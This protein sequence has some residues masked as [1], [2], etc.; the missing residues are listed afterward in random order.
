MIK[1]YLRVRGC[2]EDRVLSR[3]PVGRIWVWETESRGTKWGGRERTIQK[4]MP[5][6]Q[7]LSLGWKY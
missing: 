4:D 7:Y 5:S 3:D 2:S 6:I 1:A